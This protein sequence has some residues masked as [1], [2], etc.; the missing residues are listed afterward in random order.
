MSGDELALQDVILEAEIVADDEPVRAAEPWLDVA[1]IRARVE[2]GQLPW[3][4]RLVRKAP[5]GWR[6]WA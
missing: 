1:A 2:Y 3:L 6:G 5:P 4:A